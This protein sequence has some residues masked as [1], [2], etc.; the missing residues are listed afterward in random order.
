MTERNGIVDTRIK[1]YKPLVTLNQ[2]QQEIPRSETA[3]QTVYQARRGIEAILDGE[4]SRKLIVV[5]PCSMHDLDAALEYAS[6]LK[7]LSINLLDK[8]LVVM[9]TYF[10]K[11]RTGLG[12][13]GLIN[14]PDI[15]GQEDLNKGYRLARRIL[16]EISDMGIACATEYVDT[17]TPQLI[18]EFIAWA[19][20]GARTSYSQDHRRMASGLSSP[21]GFKNDINGDISVAVNGVLVAKETHKFP[22]TNPDG[23]SSEAETYGNP[24][25]H[26]VLR[27]GSK[28]NYDAAN[29]SVAQAM[30]RG[31][32]LPPIV[33][34][35]C[36]HNNSGKEYRRQP[37][38]FEDVTKQIR[39]G[40]SDIIGM[41]LE[42]HLS[43]G[44]VDIPNNLR[45]F[46]R[47]TLK[48]GISI[49]D[50]CIDWETT[51]SMILNAARVL[52]RKTA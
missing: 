28:P 25:C 9:R 10:E 50:S 26:I 14:D 44:K 39:D 33:M 11:P 15:N 49:T 34:V 8:F 32:G 27:G 31:N 16:S 3:R 43:A 48:Y 41:M 38:V 30:L 24:Y 7:D 2:L 46:D 35:D 21:V 18:G 40:N 45:G 4:N 13:P 29:V 12:W 51:E 22:G 20:I 23:I 47:S 19:A 42:S 6:R 5:G 37:E 52:G 1:G 17:D 36:S